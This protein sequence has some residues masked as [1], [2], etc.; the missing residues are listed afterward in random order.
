MQR[1][2]TRSAF[3]KPALAT[4]CLGLVIAGGIRSARRQADWRD[5]D[6]LSL[7]SIGDSP[8]SWRVWQSYAESMFRNGNPDDG[9]LAYHRAIDLAPSP[10]WVQNA[11]ARKLRELGRDEDAVVELRQ[12]ILEHPGQ[13]D[14]YPELAAALIGVGQYGEAESLARRVIARDGAPAIMVWLAHVADSALT[15]KIPA[16]Q[17]RIGVN[18]QAQSPTR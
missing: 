3:V 8:K 18:T 16:G 15:N 14:A 10:W 1:M 4:A 13:V 6:T 7:A 11:L 12:S 9:V 5:S 2:E 17:I